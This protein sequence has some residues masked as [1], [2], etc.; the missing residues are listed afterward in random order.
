MYGYTFSFFPTLVY[1]CFFNSLF[2]FYILWPI[3]LEFVRESFNIQPF[4]THSSIGFVWRC[5]LFNNLESIL[6]FCVRWCCCSVPQSRPTLC[7][8][9]D[10][11]TPRFPVLHHLPELAQI[12][13]H[14]VSDA[15]QPSCPLSSPSPPALR[16]SQHYGLFTWISSSHQVA[17]ELGFQLQHQS[18]QWL[19]RTGLL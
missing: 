19:F 11:S 6:M 3:Q 16:L 9:M 8:P 18:F 14:W 5:Y 12:H 17:K 7:N 13:V 1:F 15:I 2:S 10:R 4:I